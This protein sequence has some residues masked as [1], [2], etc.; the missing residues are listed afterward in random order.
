MTVYIFGTGELYKRY[1]H[2]FE[3]MDVLGLVDNNPE[4]WGMELDGRKVISPN[5]LKGKE[6]DYIILASIHYEEMRDQLLGL[7]I[8]EKKVIDKEHKGFFEC[9]SIAE[10][11]LFSDNHEKGKKVLMFSHVLNLTGA[12]VVFCRLA[13]L[14]KK[15]GY[16]VTVVAEKHSGLK[17]GIL[18]HE[19]LRERISVIM[20]P[21]YELFDIEKYAIE[22]DFFW[23][24]TVVMHKIVERLIKLN[25]NVYWWLHETDDY[26][27]EMGKEIKF[28]HA[29][30][31]FVLSGGWMAAEAY[32]K[33]SGYKV[34]RNLE[35]G[36]PDFPKKI[37]AIKK[38]DSRICFGLF[39]IY[40]ERKG[41]DVLYEAILQENNN[42][43]E[44]AEFYFVGTMPETVTQK[45]E[46]VSNVHCIGEIVPEKLFDAYEQ[47]DVL[48]CPSRFDP[49]PVVVSEAMQHR[50]LC[51]VTDKVGQ[52]RYI[53]DCYDGLV[54]KAGDVGALV[55]KV[56]WILANKN[57]L[58]AM[59]SRSYAIYE[60]H[61]SM[62]SFERNVFEL[63]ERE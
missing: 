40:C 52:S 61:F 35:Y 28:P 44:I 54:C 21:D 4:K 46:K 33:F 18:L 42:W 3:N 13:K 25:K 34:A 22:Y 10:Q 62:D 45:Y 14:L 63:L 58:D 5:E 41:Q 19:L 38:K 49:M 29:S 36:I 60:N 6:F 8:D 7:G 27:K 1:K 23:V 9:I 51:L 16:N 15:N 57:L 39:G 37:L 31:L 24:C 2:L 48:I 56:N 55:Q 50:K 47:I 20:V 53:T 17:H 59:G 43:N 11:Y 26:Y 12:P 32:V 30:N